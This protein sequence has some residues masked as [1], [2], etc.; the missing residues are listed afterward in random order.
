MVLLFSYR[1]VVSFGAPCYYGVQ[2]IWFPRPHCSRRCVVLYMSQFLRWAEVILSIREKIFSRFVPIATQC[3]TGA[4]PPWLPMSSFAYVKEDRMDRINR[5]KRSWNMSRVKG[6]NTKPEIFLRK[7]LYARGIR[8][9]FRKKDLPGRPGLVLS[10][11]R[12]VIFYTAVFGTCMKDAGT[13]KPPARARSSGKR[14]WKV[15]GP[16]TW[17]TK[18]PCWSLSGGS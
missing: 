17:R 12:A 3:F 15:T 18:K 16:R 7:L 13:P 1:V 4:N 5:E 8:Y 9:R 11:F 10:K 6:R 14:N 2:R